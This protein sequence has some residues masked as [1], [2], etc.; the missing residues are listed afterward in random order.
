MT[1]NYALSFTSSS[2]QFTF[3]N[4]PSTSIPN[5]ILPLA[6]DGYIFGPGSGMWTATI[7]TGSS[8]MFVAEWANGHNCCST[9]A[10]PFTFEVILHANGLIDFVYQAMTTQANNSLIG[11]NKGD[12]IHSTAAPQ[13]RSIAPSP[14]TALRFTYNAATA[15]YDVSTLVASATFA[16]TAPFTVSGQRQHELLYYSVDSNNTT[17]PSTD[18]FFSIDLR[19]PVTARSRQRL[20]PRLRLGLRVGPGNG[21]NCSHH[22]NPGKWQHSLPLSPARPIYAEPRRATGRP[23]ANIVVTTERQSQAL[24]SSRTLRFLP[25]PSYTNGDGVWRCSTYASAALLPNLEF[26]PTPRR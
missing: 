24:T 18:I 6:R 2:A 4:F 16:Y 9:A 23:Q 7:G 25:H 21:G 8:A 13:N 17:R 12:G 20:V 3:P 1:T 22:H 26:G 11:L 5:S 10:G 19:G 15:N 14:G